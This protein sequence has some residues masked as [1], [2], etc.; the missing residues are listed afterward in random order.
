MS[1][2]LKKIGPAF[3]FTIWGFYSAA[4]RIDHNATFKTMDQKKYIRFHYDNDF[5]TKTDCYYTQ[6]IVLEY[7]NPGL[8]NSIVSKLLLR[9]PGD[10][11]YSI[12]LNLSSYSPTSISSDNILYGDRPF[13]AIISVSTNAMV[14]SQEKAQRISS[15]FTIGLIGPAAQ[16]NE[17]QTGIHRWLKNILPKGWQHQIKNDVIVNY[18]IGLEKKLHRVGDHFLLN[19]T[20]TANVGTLT[21]KLSGG[22][23]FMTGNFNDPYK[24]LL[25]NTKKV[26]YYLYGQ[27]RGNLIGYDATLQ[28]GFFNNKNPYTIVSRDINRLTFQ[29]DAGIALNF[30]KISLSY[31]QS[32]LTKEFATGSY[33]RWGG[34]SM[35]VGF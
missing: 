9:L 12:G 6:G 25:I 22:F 13:A 14:T 17:I 35:G 33:H 34:I 18:D 10:T 2:L 31:S 7:G 29:A 16:G 32:F 5:F 30:K 23:N 27:A 8:Q 26:R 21:N 4:Q 24:S 11:R 1:S 20:I 15:S 28:G 3:F 19:A